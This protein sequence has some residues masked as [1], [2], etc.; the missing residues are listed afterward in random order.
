M[1]VDPFK[2]RALGRTGVSVTQLG[3]GSAGIGQLS[4][5]VSEEDAQ[6]A[7]A[8]AWDA[9][10]RFYDTSP[11]YGRTLSEHR[12]GHALRAK[13]R[14]DYVLST[15]VGRIFTP[16]PNR[17]RID[18][19][20]WLG[21]LPFDHYFDYSYDAIMRSY[22][23]SQQRLGITKIDL[24]LIHDMDHFHFQTDAKVHA[25]MEVLF[26]SGM[27][28]LEELKSAGLIGGIGA[29]INHPGTMNQF[30]DMVDLD[31]FLVALPYTL[32]DQFVYH[33]EMA[34]ASERGMGFIIG[35]VLNSGILATGA[36]QGAYYNYAPA[37]EDA[38]SRVRRLE[39]VCQRHKVPLVAAAL[40]FP[41][42]HPDVAAVIPGA[43]N[44]AQQQANV[45]AMQV[46]IPADFWAELKA[47]KILAEDIPTP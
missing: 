46:E 6:A 30:M 27:R 43:L 18:K 20:Q 14:E 28:A 24:L 25:H 15:K 35:G 26:T 3:Y 16:A 40:Q 10:V 7:M 2:K 12:M 19:D 41:L 13:P 38:L 5:L 47:E 32:L 31:F 9:G 42:G 44:A 1:T 17:D 37:T 29:G 22:E 45:S 34:R 39:A 8:T 36:V 33:D 23:D 11:W 21:G 4:S